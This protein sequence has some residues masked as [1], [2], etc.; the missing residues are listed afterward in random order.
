[1]H[2]DKVKDKYIPKLSFEVFFKRGTLQFYNVWD[3]SLFQ[4]YLADELPFYDYDPANGLF[5]VP[6]CDFS[7]AIKV[8][9]KEE[10]GLEFDEYSDES[11]LVSLLNY[12]F[13][14][15]EIRIHDI[16]DGFDYYFEDMFMEAIA[17]SEIVIEIV[18]SLE[19]YKKYE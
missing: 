10:K 4:E 3:E 9:L 11:L 2:L 7:K 5:T 17:G 1:V 14:T 12:C 16:T 18:L 6:N 8:L 19:T 13:E 15:N